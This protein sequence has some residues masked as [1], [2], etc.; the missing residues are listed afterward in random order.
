M[1][2]CT[3][4]IE[5]Y[6]DSVKHQVRIN[7]N[8]LYDL[9]QY[10]KDEDELNVFLFILDCVNNYL[11][12]FESKIARMMKRV[13]SELIFM[14]TVLLI[15]RFRCTNLMI[16][17]YFFT[18]LYTKRNNRSNMTGNG[19]SWEQIIRFKPRYHSQNWHFVTNNQSKQLKANYIGLPDS[20][21]HSALFI[22]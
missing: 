14:Q 18:N 4:C 2:P 16:K 6:G 10:P 5:M 9:Q 22:E 17:S 20:F 11:I 1:L 3:Y 7:S 19:E 8:I 12:I 13:I 21:R 15:L